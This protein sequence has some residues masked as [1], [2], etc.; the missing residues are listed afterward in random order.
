[1]YT[2]V[3]EL[4]NRG[5]CVGMLS[6]IDN[7]LAN[8]IRSFGLYEPFHPC[9]LSCEIGFEKPDTQSYACLIQALN[10]A[11]HEI[12]FIDDRVENIVAARKMGIDA[13]LFKSQKQIERELS[14][15]NVFQQAHVTQA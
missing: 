11:P 3:C 5:L 1:M 14:R 7:R 2:L 12:V 15:R 9:L 8:M 13:I 10:L 4:K 6:N